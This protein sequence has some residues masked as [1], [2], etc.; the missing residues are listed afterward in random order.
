MAKRCYI[1]VNGEAKKAV[2][3][4]VGVNGTARK[5]VK[6]Y[7]GVNGEAKQFWPS[8]AAMAVSIKTKI[9]DTYSSGNLGTVSIQTSIRN[10]P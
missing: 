5:V 7:V 6:G 2:K 1:G 9:Y 4:Y 10:Y 3:G 8:V